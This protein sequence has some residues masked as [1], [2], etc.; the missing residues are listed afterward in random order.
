MTEGDCLFCRVVTGNVRCE[1]VYA[2]GHTVAIMDLRQPGWPSV[3]HVLVLP[4][5]HVAVIDG[6]T[7]DQATRL[8]SSVVTVSRVLRRVL[9]PE[10]LSVWQSNGEAAGQEVPHVHIHVLTRRAGDDLLR[11]YPSTPD[12]PSLEALAPLANRLRLGLG[13]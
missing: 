4:R 8:M 1:Q 7:P 13:S 3:A 9:R 11:T 5:E 2:D 10:G 6:L 12:T